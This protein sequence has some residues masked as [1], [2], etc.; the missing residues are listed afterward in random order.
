VQVN[1]LAEEQ[2]ATLLAALHHAGFQALPL[3]SQNP[4][5]HK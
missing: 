1:T 2:L 3:N 5:A 4:I